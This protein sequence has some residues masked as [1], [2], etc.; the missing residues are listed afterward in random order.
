MAATPN[1]YVPLP[2]AITDVAMETA[3][4]NI[5][6]FRLEFVD[7]R[8]E[9][10]CG[11]FAEVFVPG[12]GESPFGMAS[13]PMDDGLEFTVS[14]AGRVTTAMHNLEVGESL[15][16]RGPLGNGF[17][18]D[19]L[20]GKN[21]VLIG[22]GFGFTTLRSLTR[23]VLHEANRGRFL[24]HSVIYGA[25]EPGLLLYTA[26]LDEWAQRTDMNLHL[27]IDREAPGWDGRVGFVP[28]VV[29]QVAPCP[30][31]AVAIVCGPPI[32]IKFT[33]PVLRELG[34]EPE[35]VLLSLEMKMKCGIGLCGR[36]NI[37]P[38]YVCKDGPVFSLA[39]LSQLP[40]EY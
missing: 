31:N 34:F 33:L 10:R 4:K 39:E 23:Y 13:S 40:D 29:E 7:D 38:K 27:T 3:D 6:T 37:G 24:E 26:E 36:C 8:F 32:M 30:D 14:R 9:Y 15:G 19:D 22:G 21:L 20:Q 1:P 11:Q 2:V 25:R 18:L 28:Q 16:V 12:Q 35:Q 17:P 5:K